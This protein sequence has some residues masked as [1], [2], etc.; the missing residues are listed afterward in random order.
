MHNICIFQEVKAAILKD[1]TD[2]GKNSGLFSFEQVNL[3]VKTCEQVNAI[4]LFYMI[5]IVSCSCSR[6][7]KERI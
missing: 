1:L 4:V 7:G 3:S 5:C 6:N 2:L